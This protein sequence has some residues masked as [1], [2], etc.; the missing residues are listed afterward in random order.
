MVRPVGFEPTTFRSGGERSIQ[1]S[2]GR[3]CNQF[4]TYTLGLRGWTGLGG[5]L[6]EVAGLNTTGAELD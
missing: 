5:N 2:Y 4:I 1:L 3:A 6:C